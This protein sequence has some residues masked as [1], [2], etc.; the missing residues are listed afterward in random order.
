[1]GSQ[2]HRTTS[3]LSSAPQPSQYLRLQITKRPGLSA[4]PLQELLVAA[5]ARRITRLSRVLAAQQ[6]VDPDALCRKGIAQHR[7]T[8]VGISRPAHEHVE[9]GVPG[10]RPGVNRDVTFRQHRYA[11]NAARLKMV[12]VNVQQRGAG[13][14]HAI[15]QGRFDMFDVVE[16]F[17]AVQVDDQVDAGATHAV[18]YGEMI[19][20]VFVDDCRRCRHRD[21]ELGLSIFLSGGTWDPQA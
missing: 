21:L 7:N 14:G 13:G 17:C 1:Y 16:A 5:W 6:L 4:R 3:R 8:G 11:G 2:V 10:L 19:L 20:A 12:Q 9:R 15:A 18:A